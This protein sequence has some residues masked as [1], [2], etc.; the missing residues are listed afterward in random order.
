MFPLKINT[1]S[2]Q[3]DQL[4]NLWSSLPLSDYA[5][6]LYSTVLDFTTK[7]SNGQNNLALG[8]AS[9]PG[10]SLHR[11]GDLERQRG[12]ETNLLRLGP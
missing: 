7:R 11:S 6:M 4:V 10:F 9:Q 5:F 1:L 12:Q 2:R 3:N 8:K